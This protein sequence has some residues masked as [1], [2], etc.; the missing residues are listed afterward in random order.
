MSTPNNTPLLFFGVS[1]LANYNLICIHSIR[2][3]QL[4][5]HINVCLT[6]IPPPLAHS[7][8]KPV[9]CS[10]LYGLNTRAQT[11]WSNA[12]GGN[13]AIHLTQPY[14]CVCSSFVGQEQPIHRACFRGSFVCSQGGFYTRLLFRK[15]N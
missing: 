12:S 10:I 15:Q 9:L 5:S 11:G 6:L 3:N 4:Q 8:I 14:A 7:F 13:N 1:P 2:P